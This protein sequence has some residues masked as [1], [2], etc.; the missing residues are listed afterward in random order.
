VN[1]F[2]GTSPIPTIEI[3]PIVDLG[4]PV[5]TVGAEQGKQP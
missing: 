1:G 5:P 2:I 4:G 3:R